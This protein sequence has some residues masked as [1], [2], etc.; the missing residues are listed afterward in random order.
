[1]P[2][3]IR[4]AGFD[5][6][7]V[8]RWFTQYARREYDVKVEED[9]LSLAA[10][11]MAQLRLSDR[12]NA[13]YNLAKGWGTLRKDMSDSRFPIK[14]MPMGLVEYAANFFASEQMRKV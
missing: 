8:S 2:C 9:F 14:R 7:E 10:K 12:S 3:I 11:A 1:M 4:I 13:L 5:I 6:A